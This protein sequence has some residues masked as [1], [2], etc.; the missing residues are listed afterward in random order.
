MK[1]FRDIKLPLQA[2]QKVG[3]EDMEMLDF[4]WDMKMPD[5]NKFLL[6][7]HVEDI[8][9]MMVFNHGKMGFVGIFLYR[10]PDIWL[11]FDHQKYQIFISP[12]LVLLIHYWVE[13][14]MRTNDLAESQLLSTVINYLEN[15]LN[16]LRNQSVSHTG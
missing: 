14:R 2:T 4:L 5:M 8:P 16:Q 15:H 3:G 10:P 12:N 6:K 9:S 7:V 1:C 13:R 11:D